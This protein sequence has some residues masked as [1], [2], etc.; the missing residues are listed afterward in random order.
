MTRKKHQREEV[1]DEQILDPT[2]G[3]SATF[4]NNHVADEE[5]VSDENKVEDKSP[6]Q[7]VEV[8]PVDQIQAQLD[9][10]KDKYIRLSAEFDNYRKRTLREK[11]DLT[12]YASEDV[13]LSI[14]PVFDDFERAMKSMD[15]SADIDAV[16]Q[17]LHLIYGKFNDF[18]KAKGVVEI[19]AIGKELNTDTHEAITKVPVQEEDKKGKIIDVIQKGYMLNDKVIRFSKVVMGE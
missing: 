4:S 6:E 3:E 10:M 17:G 13:L 5:K 9:E 2:A 16:K 14:L 11:M 1:T 8:N 18:L 19:E 7:A 12:K 15:L